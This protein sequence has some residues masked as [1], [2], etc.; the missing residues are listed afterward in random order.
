MNFSVATLKLCAIC[1]LSFA[2]LFSIPSLL[3]YFG[4]W[5]RLAIVFFAGLF[6]G[7]IA[8]PEFDPKAFNSAWLFQLICGVLSGLLAGLAFHLNHEGV[9]LT[10]IIGGLLGWSAHY[11]IKHLPIP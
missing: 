3:L 7:L 2:I 1:S 5:D 9:F 8:A 11:W 10:S 6:V 4:E